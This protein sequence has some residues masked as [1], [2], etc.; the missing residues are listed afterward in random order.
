MLL[1]LFRRCRRLLLLPLDGLA[2]Y[3][4][5]RPTIVAPTRIDLGIKK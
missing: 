1:L 4:P 3:S 2:F 5:L